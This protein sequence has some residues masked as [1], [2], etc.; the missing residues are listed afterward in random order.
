[1]SATL[2]LGI[3]V[4]PTDQSCYFTQQC[5]SQTYFCRSKIRPYI[6]H[7][8]LRGKQLVR[9]R[10]VGRHVRH[11][12]YQQK[13]WPRRD[14]IA[15]QQLRRMHYQLLEFLQAPIGLIVECHHNNRG[16]D[17]ADL[18]WHEDSHLAQNHAGV[19]QTFDAPHASRRRSMHLLRQLLIGLRGIDLQDIQDTAVNLV[20]TISICNIFMKFIT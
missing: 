2:R 13:I 1:M 14:P 18:I 16:Q 20:K 10:M 17:S 15:L 19:G 3:A 7:I 11:L 12:Y 4:H 6:A 9:Q 8:L 5:G